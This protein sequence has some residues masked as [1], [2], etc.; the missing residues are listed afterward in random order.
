MTLD[1]LKNCAVVPATVDVLKSVAVPVSLDPNQTYAITPTGGS[2]MYWPGNSAQNYPHYAW[3]LSVTPEN[4][5]MGTAE[6]QPLCGS[7]S[8][9]TCCWYSTAV[10]GTPPPLLH[11]NNTVDPFAAVAN[12]VIYVTGQYTI[13]VWFKD[14][15]CSNNVGTI[16][17]SVLSVPQ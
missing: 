15:N 17:F 16:Q 8:Q 6:L 9:E 13:W 3:S 14:D 10:L 2:I 4:C 1:G 7:Q 5:A 12:N 11:F